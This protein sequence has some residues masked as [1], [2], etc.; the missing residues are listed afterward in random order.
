MNFLSTLKL[1]LVVGF[2]V[3]ACGK[4]QSVD[5]NSR[6]Q[7]DADKPT[8]TS[9]QWMWQDVTIDEYNTIIKPLL[10]MQ[11]E[12]F[13]PLDHNLNVRAQYWVD[14]IDA[15]IRAEHPD[16][17]KNT[18]RPKTVVKID[19]SVNAFVT[20]IPVCYDVEFELENTIGAESNSG[21]FVDSQSGSME[22]WPAG[23]GCK[24][25]SSNDNLVEFVADL[26]RTLPANCRFSYSKNFEGISI[27]KASSG[28]EKTLSMYGIKKSNRLVIFQTANYVTVHSGIIA[29]MDEGSF[30]SVLAHELGH[31][32]RSHTAQLNEEYDYFY[33]MGRNNTSRKP[34]ADKSLQKQGES[35]VTASRFLGNKENFNF[36]KDAQ[37]RSEL[38]LAA[39]SI[40][41][42]VCRNGDCSEKC[43]D[44]KELMDSDDFKTQMQMFPFSSLS[45]E[46]GQGAHR[47]FEVRAKACLA[48][49]S[50][51][52][53]AVSMEKDAVGFNVFKRAV[54][55]PV[56]PD[57]VSTLGS[58]RKILEDILRVVGFRI[59]GKAPEGSETL[60]QVFDKIS[61]IFELQDQYFMN[62][63]R[64]AYV[65][66]IGQYTTEQEADDLSV[67]WL[68]DIGFDPY[69]AVESHKALG[70]GSAPRLGGFVMG[71]DDCEA[72]YNA[73]WFN[74]QEKYQ[75]VPVGDYAEVHHSQCYRMFNLT[76]E[77]EAHGWR[78]TTQPNMPQGMKW[79]SL[80]ALA[81]TVNGFARNL[82]ND[83]FS[84]EP[85]F[86]H[87]ALDDCAFSPKRLKHSH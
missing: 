11:G 41:K 10:G 79:E 50:L 25:S 28:C 86:R 68:V 73:N 15:A 16:Q 52:S 34:V 27:L 54:A 81:L 33:K 51:S 21:I 80:Q 70:A 83:V 18:P 29:A 12:P 20:P 65:A 82:V 17:L 19:K 49:I 61:S 78:A 31:Y 1:T 53:D 8:R 24:E 74:D 23:L 85:I 14:Q 39:G 67:E 87:A 72:L 77:I 36:V 42:L 30:V 57:W 37:F 22:L 43:L 66:K 56:W 7:H 58:S 71:M 2:G 44:A 60:D 48:T 6:L 9:H 26:N 38:I 64:T 4:E 84:A 5:Q 3:Y 45:D 47:D 62:A 13:L 32:Y 35:A 59:A 75:F 76:R 55:A 40:I 69:F 63:L 46:G